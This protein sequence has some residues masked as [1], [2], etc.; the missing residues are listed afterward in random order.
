MPRFS[1]YYAASNDPVPAYS[2]PFPAQVPP[3]SSNS[4]CN[5]L[6][7]CNSVRNMSFDVNY[8]AS[9]VIVIQDTFAGHLQDPLSVTVHRNMVLSSPVI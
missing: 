8:V 9:D 5:N 4:S 6:D 3:A 2:R 7:R 1:R